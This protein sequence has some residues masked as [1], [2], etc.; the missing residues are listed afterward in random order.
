M[1][2]GV[3][4]LYV[5]LDCSR[6]VISAADGV[7]LGGTE[8]NTLNVML[9]LGIIQ[10]RTNNILMLSKNKPRLENI[11][12][13]QTKVDIENETTAAAAAAAAKETVDPPKK[14]RNT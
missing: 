3:D 6:T 11:Q 1:I 5:D 2:T 7:A 4:R 13:L 14:R 9:Y 12:E 10:Q 8:I